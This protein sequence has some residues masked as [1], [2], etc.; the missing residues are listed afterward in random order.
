MFDTDREYV[1]WLRKWGRV[2][3]SQLQ[4]LPYLWSNE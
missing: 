4:F 1:I 2:D 3:F